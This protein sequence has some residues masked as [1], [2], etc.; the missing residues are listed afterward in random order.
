MVVLLF[1]S[2]HSNAAIFVSDNYLLERSPVKYFIEE[3]HGGNSLRTTTILAN[4]K[5]RERVYDTIFRM[6][7]RCELVI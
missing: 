6:P 7:W 1:S 4:E 3:M 5:D 2:S